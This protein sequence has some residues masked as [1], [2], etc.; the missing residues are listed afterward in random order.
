MAFSG[1]VLYFSSMIA[2]LRGIV[3]RHS[4]EEITLEVGGVG[5]KVAVP[6]NVWDELKDG[7]EAQLF[8]H[9]YV[10]ED[11]FDLFGFLDRNS[12]A[13]FERF[14]GMSGIGPRHGL[15]LSAV[16]RSLL[17]QAIGSQEPKLLTTV[18]GIGKKTAEKLLVDL[19]SLVEKQPEIFG[20]T[21][22][23]SQMTSHATDQDAIDALKNL[24]YD[25]GTIMHVLRDLPEDLTTTEQRVAAALR[26][27]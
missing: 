18:K 7:E 4:P 5:Y 2:T 19:K 21:F 17:M 11:R 14:I 12:R 22:D 16:P 15:E 1:D 9:S 26:S 13:L 24:G 3:H 27:L 6:M 20:T 23:A 10:R 25:T 8:I